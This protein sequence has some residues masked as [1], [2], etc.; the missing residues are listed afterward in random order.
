MPWVPDGIPSATVLTP[1]M[2]GATRQSISLVPNRLQDEGA[3]TAGP[4]KIDLA[5]P[6]RQVGE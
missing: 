4:T 6:R 5:A 1:R 3:I 2:I